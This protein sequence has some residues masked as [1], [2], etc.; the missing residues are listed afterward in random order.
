VPTSSPAD[1]DGGAAGCALCYTTIM[2]D[3]SSDQHDQA[4]ATEEY[5]TVAQANAVLGALR[6]HFSRV[7][8]LRAQLKVLYT[9][10]AESGYSPDPDGGDDELDNQPPIEV[11]RDFGV[12]RAM[13]DTLREEVDAIGE[14]G[15]SI[16]DIETGLVDWPA[17][18][19][20]REVLLC[21]RYGEA[22]VSHWHE[23]HDGFAGRQPIEALT[24][25]PA[26]AP[27]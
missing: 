11:Q 27:E 12:F 22:E 24:G 1:R 21:W 17:L 14:L 9:R 16:K 8:Q 15:C 2:S 6:A 3:T 5:Y 20:G 13:V 23:V 25:L 4:G 10:L 26:S 19:D 18:H 7:M